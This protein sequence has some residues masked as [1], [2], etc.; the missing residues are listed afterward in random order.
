[1]AV[2]RTKIHTLKTS[3]PSPFEPI[4]TYVKI[5]LKKLNLVSIYSY[6][7]EPLLMSSVLTECPIIISLTSTQTVGYDVYFFSSVLH[8]SFI[9]F[10]PF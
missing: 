5:C 10:L 8:F 3:S 1:M 9:F 6:I 7:V 2:V 4:S